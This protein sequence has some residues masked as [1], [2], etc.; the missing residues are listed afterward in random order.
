MA[1]SLGGHGWRQANVCLFVS[2]EGGILT[3]CPPLLFLVGINGSKTAPP[4]TNSRLTGVEIKM[5]FV[6]VLIERYS[7]VPPSPIFRYYE[8]GY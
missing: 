6:R 1:K 7:A 5:I 4:Q 2:F 8:H 3:G